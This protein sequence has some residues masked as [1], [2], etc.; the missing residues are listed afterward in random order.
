MRLSVFFGCALPV[1]IL[2]YESV[3]HATIHVEGVARAF[4]E[5]GEEGKDAVGDIF[6]SDDFIEEVAFGVIGGQFGYGD[7]IGFGSALCPF[8]FPYFASDNHSIGVDGIDADFVGGQFGGFI[9]QRRK[10]L[11]R[12]SHHKDLQITKIGL[13]MCCPNRPQEVLQHCETYMTR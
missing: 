11:E 2:A 5:E 10:A 6:G 12:G 9:G 8:A 4:I 1:K 3:R 7:A 13:M